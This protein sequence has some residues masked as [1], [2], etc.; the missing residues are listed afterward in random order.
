MSFIDTAQCTFTQQN[1]C[2][3]LFSVFPILSLHLFILSL[4]K[5]FK[6][7]FTLSRWSDKSFLHYS[8]SMLQKH[9][10]FY[11]WCGNVMFILEYFL[12]CGAKNI[13]RIIFIHSTA[14]HHNFANVLCHSLG[15]GPISLIICTTKKGAR[16]CPGQ[17][18]EK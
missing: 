2:R 8:H 15:S 11:K 7:N 17:N 6:N 14:C 5:Y 12:Y 9:I 16:G 3:K 4:Q 13:I 10:V 18:R 1:L